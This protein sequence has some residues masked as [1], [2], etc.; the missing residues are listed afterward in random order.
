MAVLRSRRPEP[1]EEA[2]E[3]IVLSSRSEEREQHG[4]GR[5]QDRPDDLSGV[6]GSLNTGVC[7]HRPRCQRPVD[8]GRLNRQHEQTSVAELKR[9]FGGGLV[10]EAL[11]LNVP[12]MELDTVSKYAINILL[13]FKPGEMPMRP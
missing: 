1:A 7:G 2:E 4:E 8:R 5:L 12:G 13:D 10:D 9:L 6:C 11:P 3:R